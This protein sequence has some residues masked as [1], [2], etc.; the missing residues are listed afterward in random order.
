MLVWVAE[1]VA[2][3]RHFD[4]V[5][6]AVEDHEL[7][8]ALA[9]WNLD[10]VVTGSAPDGTSRVARIA[11]LDVPVV[12]VQGDQ[13]LIDSELLG[14]LVAAL[15][16]GVITLAAPWAG[17]PHD[18]ARVKV[19]PGPDFSRTWAPGA[20]LHVGVY[21]FGPGWVQRCAALPRS[22]RAERESLEQLSWIAG[23]VPLRVESVP[24]GTPSVDTPDDLA[25]VR[26]LLAAS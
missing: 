11:P 21:G 20:R 16:D 23:G 18:P 25:R 8:E 13:P 24:R 3:C 10:V 6:V 12:N 9:P 19:L 17:D 1:R 7:A 22:G 4:R 5:V 26:A 15:G 2:A 14:A